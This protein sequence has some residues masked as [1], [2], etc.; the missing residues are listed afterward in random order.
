MKP[1]KFPDANIVITKPPSAGGM[2][3]DL[4]A[5]ADGKV[6]I[7]CWELTNDE[8]IDLSQTKKIYLHILG[9]DMPCALLTVHSPFKRDKKEDKDK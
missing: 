1:V 3:K 8:L 5:F 2:V 4:P 9:E 7:S 6:I